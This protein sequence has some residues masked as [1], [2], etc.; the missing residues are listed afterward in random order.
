MSG[1]G[2]T[3]ERPGPRSPDARSAATGPGEFELIARLAEIVGPPS[4]AGVVLGIGDD[5]AAWRPAPDRLQV[6]TTDMLVEGVHFRL[7]WTSADDLGWKGL[8]VNLSDLAAMGAL[9]SWALVSLALPPERRELALELY[10]GMAELARRTGT[11]IVGGD[12]VRSSGPLVVSLALVGEADPARLLRRDAA[13]P[14]D[15]LAVTGVLGASAAGLT[16]LSEGRHDL[17]Q[18]GEPLLTAHHRP[19]PRLA[20]G[21]LLG[22]HGVH[23]AID[24]S[25]GLASEAQHLADASGV[26]IEVDI[27]QLPLHPAAVALLGETRARALALSGGEDYELLFTAPEAVVAQL[28]RASGAETSLTMVGRVLDEGTPG[29]VQLLDDGR[30]VHLHEKGYVAF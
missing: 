14:G 9:P 10:R 8:A 16:L 5:A 1:G 20:T 21:Q 28:T 29:S 25:D 17:L 4:S 18:R 11:A 2:R 15:V 19:W 30:P 12:T 22:A 13:R 6:A 7:D 3:R 23:C 26:A 27:A 24:I